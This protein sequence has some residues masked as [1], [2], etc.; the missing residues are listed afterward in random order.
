MFQ[1]TIYTHGQ[2]RGT[3]SDYCTTNYNITVLTNADGDYFTLSIGDTIYGQ[4]GVAGFVAYSNVS[5]DTN[6]GPFRIAEIDSNG[7]VQD[8]SV[9]VGSSCVPL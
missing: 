8:I 5:T 4:G 3:C 9:C 6:T 1:P 7:V 2:V